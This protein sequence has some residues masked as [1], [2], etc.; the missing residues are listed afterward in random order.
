MSAKR[1]DPALPQIFVTDFDASCRFYVEKLG[2][3]IGYTYGEPAF[4]GLVQR[5]DARLNLRHVDVTPFHDGV[6][7]REALLSAA[8]TVDDVEG[9]YE[10]LRSRGVPFQQELT[11]QPWGALDFVARDPDEN[12]IGFA[13]IDSA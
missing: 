12:L 11:R 8:I 5:G 3:E 10:E 1:L 9:L 6:R 2:F 4:Y 7:D 13:R